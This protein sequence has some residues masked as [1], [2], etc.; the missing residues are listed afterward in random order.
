[1]TT[2]LSIARLSSLNV[3]PRHVILKQQIRQIQPLLR[4][5]FS[6]INSYHLQNCLQCN[7]AKLLHSLSNQFIASTQSQRPPPRV[8]SSNQINPFQHQLSNLISSSSPNH[9]ATIDSTSQQQQQENPPFE[10][11]VRR[12]DNDTEIERQ[13]PLTYGLAARRARRH[14]NGLSGTVFIKQR[15]SINQQINKQQQQQ[16]QSQTAICTPNDS[17]VRLVLPF[18]SSAVLRSRY[19]LFDTNLLRVGIVLED[20]DALAADVAYR[21]VSLAK[22]INTLDSLHT[23]T[24][25]TLGMDRLKFENRMTIDTDL[26]LESRIT[27]VGRSSIEVQVELSA[28]SPE[29][30]SG[31]SRQRHS[32]PIGLAT[33]VMVARDVATYKASPVP[34]LTPLTHLEKASFHLGSLN[35]QRRQSA[36]QRSLSQSPPRE[37]EVAEVHSLYLAD[38]DGAPYYQGAPCVRQI[39]TQQNA[40]MLAQG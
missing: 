17:Y 2:S 26:V 14:E 34:P 10:Y 8:I 7:N 11:I 19:Q 35:R 12:L 40:T 28:L 31:G 9:N 25:V 22:G 13:L 4:N 33:F 32:T 16:Q 1:M 36:A 23:V 27:W 21:H 24:I 38:R 37:D 20:C 29:E 6:S 30:E 15:K 5:L 39:D 3:M 18:T